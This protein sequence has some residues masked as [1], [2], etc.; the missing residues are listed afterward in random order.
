MLVL[1]ETWGAYSGGKELPVKDSKL[2]KEILKS[3][4]YRTAL[5]ND[6]RNFVAVTL[7]GDVTFDGEINF[8]GLSNGSGA[9]LDWRSTKKMGLFD[10]GKDLLIKII[11]VSQTEILL[12]TK[13]KPQENHSVWT[14]LEGL[15][16]F[17][18]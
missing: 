3:F 13:G 15:D 5:T 17:R 4:K 11:S 16:D 12:Y 14:I 10:T 1:R 18:N 2:L 6:S 8:P 9:K 7:R